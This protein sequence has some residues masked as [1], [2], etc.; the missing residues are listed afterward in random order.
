MDQA[1]SGLRLPVLGAVDRSASQA[2]IGA[3]GVGPSQDLQSILGIVQAL[4]P[5]L[6]ALAAI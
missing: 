6:G 4:T 1:Q 5:I 3:G 2:T